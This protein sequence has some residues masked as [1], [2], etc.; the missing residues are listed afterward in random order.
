M[1]EKILLHNSETLKHVNEVRKWMWELIK[2][3]DKRASVHDA[4]KFAE[5]ELSVFAENTPKLAKVEYG[6]EAYKEVMKEVQVAIDHHYAKN[7]HHPEHWTKGVEDM[8][9]LDLVEML[10]DWNAATLR[11]K[12]GNIHKSIDINEARFNINPQLAN[13]MRNTVNRYFSP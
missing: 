5:P 13:I 11:N 3:L 12:N 9:L 4:S 2:Q 1:N 10:C 6:G 8:D 7:T